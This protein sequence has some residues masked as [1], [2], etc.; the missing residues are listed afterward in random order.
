MPLDA[1]CLT[2]V[3]DELRKAIEGGKID[4]IYQPGRYEIIMAVRGNQGNVKLL[5]S[6]NPGH[7]RLQ[8]TGLSRENP[9]TPPM[10]CMLLRKHLTGARI[11]EITQPPMERVADFR[12]ETIDELGDRVERRLVLE[13]MG[14]RANL[15]LLDGAGRILDCLRRVDS[16]MS[17]QRQILP[18]MFYRL[19]PAPEKLNHLTVDETTLAH[20]FENP[21]GRELDKLILDGF[22]G[23]SPLIAREIAF[24]TQDGDEH[25]AFDMLIKIGRAHV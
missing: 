7:P 6:A 9:G 12:L 24:R 8:L 15:I 18:G 5:F 4:K 21:N 22:N 11:L 10:F 19:P 2:A 1:I 25:A 17:A 13:C 23:I 3:L 14:R 16:D 20:V